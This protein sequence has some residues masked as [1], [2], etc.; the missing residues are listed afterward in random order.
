MQTSEY[1]LYIHVPFCK[2]RCSYC[3]FVS[4]TDFSLVEAYFKALELE[5]EIWSEELFKPAIKSVYV[6]G[7]TPSDVDFEY[8][9]RVLEKARELFDFKRPEVTVEINPNCQYVGELAK[10][11]VNR[12]SI[13]LQA[14][15]D[16]VLRRVKRRHTVDDFMR[17]WEEVSKFFVNVN[18]DFIV[19]LPAETDSTIDRNMEIVKIT[20]PKHVSVYVLETHDFKSSLQ[21]DEV[22]ERYEKFL[23][24]LKEMGYERYEISNF[25]KIGYEC[26]HNRVYWRNGDYIGVGVSAGGHIGFTRYVNTENIHLYIRTIWK[27]EHP[28]G[29][30][31]ENDALQE[32]KETLFMG[33]RTAEGV[34][35]VKIGSLL[36]N[37][38]FEDLLRGLE[39]YVVFDEGWIKL[40]DEGMNF[41]AWVIGEVLGRVEKAVNHVPR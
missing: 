13:G 25:A 16:A 5:L 38:K 17:T 27:G 23:L 33:L 40:T 4:Y 41:S 29:Y 8:L 19:G 3:D 31:R 26:V 28:Y 30:Y 12:V 6:G 37:L 18:V 7:G 20:Q 24:F 15:D 21:N 39:R 2:S 9:S 35:L 34:N 36:S 14:A 22:C 32:A 10:I 1:G 11:G